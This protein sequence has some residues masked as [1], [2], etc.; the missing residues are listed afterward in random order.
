L[1]PGRAE[2]LYDDFE[3]IMV[4]AIYQRLGAAVKQRQAELHAEYENDT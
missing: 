1:F 2:L 4:A 3:L